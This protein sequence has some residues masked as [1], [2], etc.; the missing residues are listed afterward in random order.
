[1]NI[2]HIDASGRHEGSQ[3]RILSQRL[4]DKL[5]AKHG[6]SVNHRDISQGLP[7]VDGMMIGAYYTPAESR[8]PEQA[9]KIALSDVLV[10]ELE[11]ADTIVLGVPM[12]NF[13]APAAFKAWIDLVARPK[14]TFHY[15]EQGPVGLLKDKKVYLVVTTGGVPIGSPADFVTSH[16]KF[17]LGF[18]GITDV[19]VIAADQLMQ[20]AAAKFALAEQSIEAIAA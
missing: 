4:V 14:R 6:A 17:V 19:T 3:S 5:V 16:T 2:L 11:A 15:T 1:M 10:D 9:A 18:L 13:G 8:S 7:F 20:D 12:Y